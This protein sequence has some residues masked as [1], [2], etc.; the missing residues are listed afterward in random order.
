MAQRS[1]IVTWVIVI[2]V[3]LLAIL[4]WWYYAQQSY[5]PA[6]ENGTEETTLSSEKQITNFRFEDLTPV[7]NGT[8]DNA[9]HTVT[10]TVPADTDITSLSPTIEASSGATVSPDPNAAQNFTNPVLYTVIAE[11]GTTQTYTVDVTEESE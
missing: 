9:A 10:V 7:V 5:A 8:I 11:D 3:I 2:I 6:P 4:A 1:A